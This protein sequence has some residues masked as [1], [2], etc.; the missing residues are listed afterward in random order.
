MDFWRHQGAGRLSELLGE[1]TLDTDIFLRTLGWER[2]AQQELELLDPEYVAVLEAYAAGVN[3]YLAEHSGSE[4]SLEYL[5]LNL[6]NPD[7]EPA[8][9]TPINTLTWQKAMAWDLGSSYLDLEITRSLLSK[10]LTAQEI[11]FLYPEYPEDRPVIV[12]G[13]STGAVEE[14]GSYFSQDF[15]LAIS[16]ALEELDAFL[17]RAEYLSDGSLTGIGS[18]SWAISGDL[19]DT[20]MPYLANDPHLVQQ[21]PSIWYQIGLHCVQPTPDCQFDVAGFSFAGAP[22]VIIGHNEHI[23]WGFTNVG[24]DVVDLYIEKINPDNPNQYEYRGE[25]VD[26]DT[27]TEIIE[28][29]GGTSYELTV[30]STIHG[31][32]IT[33]SYGLTGTLEGSSLDLPEQYAISIRWTALEPSYVF[34]AIY[35][36][37]KASSWEEFRTAAQNFNSPSQNLL[38]A[39]V[40]GNIGYQMPGS[41]PLRAPGDEGKFPKP[42]WTGAYDWYGYI[43]FENLP[44][45]LNPSEGFIVTANNAVIGP[46]YPFFITDDWDYGLRAQRIVDLINAED[47]V[48]SLADIQQ[49]QADN[50]SI[51]AEILVPVLLD[52]DLTVV[53]SPAAASPEQIQQTQE[54]IAHLDSVRALLVGW[55]Y[56]TAIDSAPAALFNAFWRILVAET[57]NE[58]LPEYAWVQVDSRAMELVRQ[59]IEIPD[60][61]WWD[62]YDTS[63]TEDRDDIL[64]LALSLAV[65]ELEEAYGAD[66]Q[67]WTWGEMHTITFTHG[68]MDSFPVINLLFNRG[69]YQTAGGSAIVNATYWNVDSYLVDWVPSMR[70]VVDLSDIS[71]SFTVHT[72]GESGHAF[73]R[74]YTDM[75]DLWRLIEYYP[76]YWER[77]DVQANAESHLRLEP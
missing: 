68:V 20:G 75:V 72:T 55:D 26:M 23:V 13:T 53:L 40:Y 34:P 33:D 45:T 25:W 10:T 51:I 6:I 56:Q 29:A 61:P 37:N 59:L 66:P 30:Q 7:Y 19:T 14:E 49:M 31:P 35:Q 24:P 62:R 5:F 2:I 69:P 18:N 11:D 8:P 70:M 3:A 74:H 57:F 38:Y 39:D 21:M 46:A 32:I 50:Y 54:H 16:P 60:S 41:I 67:D 17:A 36:F 44:Y 76:M 4:L 58:Q 27:F 12:T 73:S 15:M 43:P 65:A 47:G 42:G 64:A 28:V 77:D 1:A 71:N 63:Q 48:I 9:W 22:G 52:V